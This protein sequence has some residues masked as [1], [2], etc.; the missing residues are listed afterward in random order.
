MRLSALVLFITLMTR[1]VPLKTFINIAVPEAAL[2][3]RPIVP[4]EIHWFVTW[5]NPR[6]NVFQAFTPQGSIP[7]F[8][9]S[10]GNDVPVRSFALSV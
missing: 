2:S 4:K 3:Y 9:R 10:Y 5:L 7:P 8:P 1:P 6:G